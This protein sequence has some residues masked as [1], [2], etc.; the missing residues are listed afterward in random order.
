MGSEA[1]A[2]ESWIVPHR[3]ITSGIDNLGLTSGAGTS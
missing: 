2:D 3:V 1:Q